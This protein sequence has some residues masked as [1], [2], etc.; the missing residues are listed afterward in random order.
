M[1]VNIWLNRADLFDHFK[2][3]GATQ[4]PFLWDVT[5]SKFQY[6]VYQVFFPNGKFYIGK[7]IGRNGHI[8]RYFGSWNYELVANDFTKAELS[9]FTV[10]RK[11]LFESD[12]K[13]AVGREEMR[14]IVE[15]GANDPTKGYHSVP[16]FRG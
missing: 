13:K 6:V 15:L 8:I 1:V 11:I 2:A 10:R 14:L 12:C 5:M 7:D 16:K 4:A 9:D 3:L